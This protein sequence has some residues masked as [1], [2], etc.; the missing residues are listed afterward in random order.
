MKKSIL[1]CMMLFSFCFIFFGNQLMY[2]HAE[3]KYI[4]EKTRYFT[5]IQIQQG[6]TL[7][8]IANRFSNDSGLTV[9]SY[10]DELIRM[11]GLR[12]ETIHAG[13][14]LTVVYFSE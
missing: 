8:D 12:N 11:N 1:I 10:M 9:Q 13:E 3:E 2:V 5:S 7:W 14:Y 4:P 6:E